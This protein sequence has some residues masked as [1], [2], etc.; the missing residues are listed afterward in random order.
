MK[1]LTLFP[2]IPGVELTNELSRKSTGANIIGGFEFQKKY[3]IALQT[4]LLLI[5]HL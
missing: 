3:P 1:F 5:L 2:S 4:S